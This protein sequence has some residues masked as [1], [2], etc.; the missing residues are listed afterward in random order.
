MRYHSIKLDM[1]AFTSIK[2][3]VMSG[4]SFKLA[5]VI[6]TKMIILA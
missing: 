6:D 3:L 5:A 2:R 4:F 1:V